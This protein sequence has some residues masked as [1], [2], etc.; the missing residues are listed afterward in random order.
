VKHTRRDHIRISRK[1]LGYCHPELHAFMD[2]LARRYGWGHRLL[3]HD[4]KFCRF[5][6]RIHRELEDEAFLHI[7]V[8]Y[9]WILPGE[10]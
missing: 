9:G 2:A 4:L 5:V 3:R 10:V 6:G 8:D 7:L 1:I